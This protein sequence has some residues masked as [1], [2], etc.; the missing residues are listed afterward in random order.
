MKSNQ[1]QLKINW[2]W[3]NWKY[4][5]RNWKQ[6]LGKLKSVENKLTAN[7]KCLKSIENN[8]KVNWK[9]KKHMAVNWNQLNE[10]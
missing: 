9:W 10:F 5:G 1:N 8:L 6:I 3:L 7:C 2:K 4:I